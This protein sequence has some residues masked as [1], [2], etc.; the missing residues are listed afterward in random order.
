MRVSLK[1]IARELN[2]S[3][4]AV[5]RALNDLPGVSDT[6]RLR[7]KEAA[8]RMGYQ[9]YLKASLV[10][11][12]ERNMKFIVILYGPIGGHLV[13]QIQWGIDDR[14]RKKGYFEL[15]YMIDTFHD[16]RSE[17]TKELFL[18]R[19]SQERGVVGV[20]SCY[21]YLTDVLLARLYKRQ[22]PVVLLENF[23]DYGRCVTIDNVKASYRAVAKFVELGRRRI[24]LI[25]P[26]PGA[27]HVWN[28][29]LAGYKKALKE[30]GLEYDPT[31]IVHENWVAV[32]GGGHATRELLAQKPDVDAILYAGDK[33]A[34]GGLKVLRDTGRRVPQDVAVIG[35]DD[36][37]ADTVMQP[38]LS[39]V[40]QP[41]RKMAETGLGLLLDSIE[42]GDLA[43]RAVQLDTELI[44]RG[45][46]LEDYK[47]EKWT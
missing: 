13:E 29:R 37:E 44:L 33:Q 27:E 36:E 21:V 8:A 38:T 7:I 42:K 24:A 45:S 28:D 30:G 39:S 23:T 5:S 2:V 26:P 15:R 31:L 47:E 40:R 35:F 25:M 34:Y 1:D 20:L 3:T 43:H 12:Y 22:I 11:V 4:S 10:N 18:N 32:G 41:I 16:L 46:V 6:L 14:I 19:V 17:D 9:K